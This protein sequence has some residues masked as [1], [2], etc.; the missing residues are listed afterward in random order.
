MTMNRPLT[1]LAPNQTVCDVASIF[2]PFHLQ[3]STALED[4]KPTS[5]STLTEEELETARKFRKNALK[6][7][8]THQQ[9]L[10]MCYNHKFMAL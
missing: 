4:K 9:C 2:S 8:G 3:I 6:T 5:N 1:P 10:R 7:I